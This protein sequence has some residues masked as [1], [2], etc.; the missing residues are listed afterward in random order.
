MY[1]SSSYYVVSKIAAMSSEV[2]TDR[3]LPRC[4]RL[5]AE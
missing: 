5:V 1:P 3:N 4:S 2:P